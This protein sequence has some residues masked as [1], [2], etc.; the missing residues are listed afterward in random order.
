MSGI[1]G[2]HGL[3]LLVVFHRFMRSLSADFAGFTDSVDIETNK[4]NL[5]LLSS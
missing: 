5:T 3:D 4:S 2:R 1:T